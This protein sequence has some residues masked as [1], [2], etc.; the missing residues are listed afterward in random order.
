MPDVELFLSIL[1]NQLI[2]QELAQG[3]HSLIPNAKF[4]KFNPISESEVF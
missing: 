4:I 3:N 2:D 1:E